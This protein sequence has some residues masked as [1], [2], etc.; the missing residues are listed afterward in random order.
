[1]SQPASEW[2]DIFPF[3]PY[4]AQDRAISNAIEVLSNNGFYTFEGP[5]GTGKTLIALTASLSVI[6]NPQTDLER[7]LVVTSKKQ[8]MSAFEDDLA[9]INTSQADVF[10]SVTLVGKSDLCPYAETGDIDGSNMYQRCDELKQGTDDITGSLSA[11][12]HYQNK[13]TAANAIAEDHVT[14]DNPL[15]VDGVRT[16]YKEGIPS[17]GDDYCP[18]FA[19]YRVDDYTDNHPV[20]PQGVMDARKM[21]RRGA[22]AGTCPHMAMK[23]IAPEA[24]VLIGNYAHAFSPRTVE[25]FTGKVL[26]DETILIVDEA[27]DLVTSVRDE[28]SRS[29]T[30]ETLHQAISDVNDVVEWSSN[31]RDSRTRLIY[32]MQ[33]RGSFEI[34]DIQRLSVFL[35]KLNAHLVDVLTDGIVEEYGE[36]WKQTFSSTGFD[37]ELGDSFEI[38]AQDREAGSDAIETWVEEAFSEEVWSDVLYTCYVV[39]RIQDAV[40]EKVYDSTPPSQHPIEKVQDLLQ[41]WLIG[42]YVSY[43]RQFK[44]SPPRYDSE[45]VADSRPWRHAFKATVC[46]DNCI[47]Q[48]ELSATF[49]AFGAGIIQS[50]TLEP[51][52]VF[53]EE[54]GLDLIN[55]G[56]QP[57]SSLVTNAADR[58]NNDSGEDEVDSTDD[59]ATSSRPVRKQRFSTTFPESNRGSYIVDI[60]KFTY[61]NRWPPEDNQ[62]TREKY[63]EAIT[64]VAT[65]TPGNV[66]VFMPSYAEAEWAETILTADSTVDKPVLSD[67][68]T[69]NEV[70]EELKAEFFAGQEKVLTTSL[71][72]TLVEGVDFSGDKLHAAIVCGVPISHTGGDLSDA[73]QAAYGIRFGGENGFEYAYSV[74]AVRKTRQAIGRVIRGADEVGVR[75]FAD[76]RYATEDSYTSVGQHLPTDV[77]DE[78]QSVAANELAT[79]LDSFWSTRTP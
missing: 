9:E 63:A 53:T 13:P 6:A 31:E 39:S 37:P 32:A 54:T 76:E 19:R 10:D 43:Y 20:T 65:T 5:C 49:D 2:R 69:S 70:T 46:I 42:D 52:D 55:S 47:P 40:I 60:D 57:S 35:T 44:L 8:Q 75:V 25:G 50:A 12:G 48:R 79:T 45:S 62:H 73:I 41:R 18:F 34:E 72:G 33:E 56:D 28:L 15:R 22:E 38:P 30:F 58:Y 24:D 4:S 68:S 17:S 16:P 67:G 11:K 64:S 27:H 23:Q 66:L 21:R 26:N 74:P 7:A 29:I 77:Q 3:Q 36:Q 61:G 71:R 78:F 1:M 51:M 14:G 59:A